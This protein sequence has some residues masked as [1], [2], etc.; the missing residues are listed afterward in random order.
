MSQIDK[1]LQGAVNEVNQVNAEKA[2]ADVPPVEEKKLEKP[3]IEDVPAEP[4]DKQLDL[5]ADESATKKEAKKFKV[6][7]Y[8]KE[9]EVE[10]KS[11]EELQ[12]YVQKGY[13]IGEKLK[14]VAKFQQQ[15]EEKMQKFMEEQSFFEKD[16]DEWYD[17]KFGRGKAL[18]RAENR[19]IEAMK[20]EKMKPE[21]REAHEFK[22]KVEKLKK[23]EAEL[24]ERA[25]KRKDEEM[26]NYAMQRL[27]DISR[28]S[29]KKI[30][31][32][33][34]TPY[35]YRQYLDFIR[36]YLSNSEKIY[37]EEI[38]QLTTE[39]KRHMDDER[40][41][42]LSSLDGEQLAQYIGKDGVEKIRAFL[43]NGGVK[44]PVKKEEPKK[45]EKEFASV[46]DYIKSL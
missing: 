18:E 23:E 44:P 14:E 37:E 20:M 2:K 3:A 17:R 12:E 25:Q 36:P 34:P 46:R 9:K 15:L 29:L 21:E 30:G 28:A 24:V 35:M 27:D 1:V 40:G 8:G 22:S 39:F 10:V 11:D 43:L 38:H 42:H 19:V 4:D 7:S 41:G 16:P 45:K 5:I 33:S 26:E 6:K 31:I 32:E 13:A